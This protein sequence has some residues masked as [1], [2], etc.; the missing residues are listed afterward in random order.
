M[1]SESRLAAAA[2]ALSS[3]SEGRLSID[4]AG[5]LTAALDVLAAVDVWQHPLGFTYLDLTAVSGMLGARLRLHV[6][7]DRSLAEADVLGKA[8]DHIWALKSVVLVGRLEDVELRAVASQTGRYRLARVTYG[9]RDEAGRQDRV[10]AKAGLFDLDVVRRRDIGP[11][12]VYS[13]P[14]GHLHMTEVKKIPTATLLLAKPELSTGPVIATQAE[15]GAEGR[16][17]ARLT[18]DRGI[19]ARDLEQALMALS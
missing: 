4:H 3:A 11:S 15:L 5:V 1:T 2:K 17:A 13:L 18:L 8:H 19:A 16:S 10:D 9:S 12:R 6:W 7:T 14:P